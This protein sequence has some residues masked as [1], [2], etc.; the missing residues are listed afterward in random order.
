[1]G[2]DDNNVFV[3]PLAINGSGLG[4]YSVTLDRGQLRLANLKR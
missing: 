3:E 2:A 4:S 1:M